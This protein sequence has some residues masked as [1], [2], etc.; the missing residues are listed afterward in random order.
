MDNTLHPGWP[1]SNHQTHKPLPPISHQ[2]HSPPSEDTLA[3]VAAPAPTPL[4]PFLPHRRDHARSIHTQHQR[5]HNAAAVTF[6][7]SRNHKRL[8]RRRQ[9]P[10]TPSSMRKGAET[11][12]KLDKEELAHRLP[13]LDNHPTGLA[14]L[15]SFANLRQ[16]LILDTDLRPNADRPVAS[17]QLP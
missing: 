13:R 14:P 6:P 10:Y 17:R 16:V 5:R 2:G 15:M 4:L 7:Q 3:T 9:E 1:P 11:H 8:V 12:Y